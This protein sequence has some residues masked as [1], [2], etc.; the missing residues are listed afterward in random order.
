MSALET[1]FFESYTFDEIIENSTIMNL[2]MYE[3]EIRDLLVLVRA[4]DTELE[5]LSI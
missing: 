1:N 4:V 3:V 2:G 5:D